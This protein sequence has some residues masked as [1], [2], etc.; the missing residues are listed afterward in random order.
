MTQ[1]CDPWDGHSWW[2]CPECGY[3]CVTIDGRTRCNCGHHG[4]RE[5]VWMQRM[6]TA[7]DAARIKQENTHDA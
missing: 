3:E 1:E 5:P 2:K 6:G 7:E 4:A